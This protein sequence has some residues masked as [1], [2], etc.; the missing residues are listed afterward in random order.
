MKERLL[1]MGI[2]EENCNKILEMLD[3]SIGDKEI[4]DIKLNYEIENVLNSYSVK[5]NKAVKALL[6]MEEIKFD[7]SGKLTG[8]KEQLDNLKGNKETEYLFNKQEFKGVVPADSYENIPNVE[9]MNYTQLCAYYGKDAIVPIYIEV[10]DGLRLQRA[11]DRERMQDKPK[12][13]EL[14]RRFLADDADF[15]EEALEKAGITRHFENDNLQKTVE[16]IAAFV[17][18]YNG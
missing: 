17:L 8:I 1:E 3:E 4:A 9:D 12:Y 7:E 2:D 13:T 18:S 6:N 15:A 10:E 11:L 16:E 5:T 14:C